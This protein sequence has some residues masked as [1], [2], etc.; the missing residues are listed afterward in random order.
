MWNNDIL[1]ILTI[2]TKL[3]Y[4]DKRMESAIK[5]VIGKQDKMGR[6]KMDFS[7]NGRMHARVEQL[8]QPSK[9]ITLWALTVIKRYYS[10]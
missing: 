1:E 8:D 9:W 10:G 5:K 2:L 7:F 3:G 6:W 4:R